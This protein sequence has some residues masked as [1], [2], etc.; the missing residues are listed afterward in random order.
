MQSKMFDGSNSITSVSDVSDVQS[1][2][3]HVYHM[4]CVWCI[5]DMSDALMHPSVWVWL[6]DHDSSL[7]SHGPTCNWLTLS[8]FFFF[9]NFLNSYAPSLYCTYRQWNYIHPIKIKVL[10]NES[11]AGKGHLE[12]TLRYPNCVLSHLLSLVVSSARD[13]NDHS[14]L[15]RGWP[16]LKPRAGGS[17][18]IQLQTTALVNTYRLVRKIGGKRGRHTTNSSRAVTIMMPCASHCYHRVEGCHPHFRAGLVT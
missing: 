10:W 4:A 6:D 11:P 2:V 12:S 15:H 8:C 1:S 3:Q 7:F 14:E 5:A 18:C 9:Y 13:Q 16:G 17:K